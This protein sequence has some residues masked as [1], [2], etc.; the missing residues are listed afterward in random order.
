MRAVFVC[1]SVAMLVTACADQYRYPCQDPK[2]WGKAECSP[3]LCEANGTCTKDLV[4]ESA[5]EGVSK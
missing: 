4:T 2:N 3:P 5:L 1:L